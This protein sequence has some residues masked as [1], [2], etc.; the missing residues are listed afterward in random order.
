MYKELFSTLAV[1]VTF[2][3]FIPYIRSIQ[4]GDTKPHVFSWVV[5]GLG[6]LIVSFAQLAGRGGPGAWVIGVS[7]LITSYIALLAYLKRGDTVI[8]KTDWMFFGAALC[9]LPCWFFTSDPLW[10]VVTLTLVDLFGF[11]P[12]IRKAYHRPHEES[13]GFFALSFGRNLLVILAL[14]HY[15]LTTVLFPAA[16][17]LACLLVS[18]MLAYRRHSLANLSGESSFV[19]RQQHTQPPV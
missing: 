2:V 7:G 14:D 17:G 15:S 18:L 8:T 13:G 3:L 11:G 10:A 5:W 9:A 6:T 4:C 19:S 12:T 16:V 1:V